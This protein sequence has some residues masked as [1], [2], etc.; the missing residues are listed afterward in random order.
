M[1][2]EM[3]KL[4]N[5]C[6]KK[7]DNL[8]WVA[9]EQEIAAP[10]SPLNVLSQRIPGRGQESNPVIQ[11]SKNVWISIHKML[12]VSPYKQIYSSLWN[13]PSIKGGGKFLYWDSWLSRNITSIVN[14]IKQNI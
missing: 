6:K 9:I 14:L 4:V 7:V 10:F 8:G 13:N 11:H 1:A 5:H 2:F 3:S 12:K